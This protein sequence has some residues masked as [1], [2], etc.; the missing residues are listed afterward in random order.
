MNNLNPI[1]QALLQKNNNVNQIASLL[2]GNSE[3]VYQNL[4]RNNPQFAQF[5]NANKGKTPE[6][7][8]Q[9]YGINPSIFNQFR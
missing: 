1:A 2:N 5:V 8:A 6:Q 7:I 4:M 3:E 9:A